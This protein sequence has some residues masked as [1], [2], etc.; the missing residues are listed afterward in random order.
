[1]STRTGGF[2]DEATTSRL[3]HVLPAPCYIF[4]DSHL[5]VADPAR[6]MALLDFLRGLRGRA[7]SLLINGDLFDFWFEWRW[8]MP[9]R[10]Y[11]VLAALADLRDDGIPVI[12]IA[13]NHDCWGGEILR[14]DVGVDYHVG[15]WEGALGG[16]H[17]RVEHGDGLRERED[18]GYRALRRVVRNPLSI[19]TFRLLHPD[20]ATRLALGS[21]HTS[22]TLRPGDKGVGLRN[23]AL[24]MLADEP[25][26]ELVLF[27]HSHV[28]TLE[29][30]DGGG[31]YANSG[32]WLYDPMYLRVDEQE[33]SLFRWTGSAEGDCLHRVERL[34]EKA[35]RHA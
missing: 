23:V 19:R 18:R 4:S 25:S 27:G 31:V 13:G 1:L 22:R 34:P 6:E 17:T 9:R 8:V 30:T 7:G 26:L 5:G 29:R 35:L 33:V 2:V 11:R 12:W 28:P 14:D 15:R 24:Q 21:S 32:A 16:W 20:F 3:G 10:G